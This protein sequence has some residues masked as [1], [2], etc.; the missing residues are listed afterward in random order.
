MLVLIV[1]VI[2]LLGFSYFKDWLRNKYWC[3]FGWHK[4]D[5]YAGYDELR[6]HG[7]AKCERCGVRYADQD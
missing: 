5:M 2:V 6:V 1:V 7:R 3:Q 4:W